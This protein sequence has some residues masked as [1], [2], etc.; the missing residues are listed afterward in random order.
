MTT[1]PDIT[2]SIDLGESF[3]AAKTA[4]APLDNP[5]MTAAAAITPSQMMG[6]TKMPATPANAQ[7]LRLS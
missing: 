3:S 7:K 4:T 1:T 2:S 6:G 5:Q